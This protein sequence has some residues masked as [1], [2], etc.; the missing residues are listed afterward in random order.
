MVGRWCG[1]VARAGGS[2]SVLGSAV[3]SRQ[4]DRAVAQIRSGAKKCVER[5][6][7]PSCRRWIATRELPVARVDEPGVMRAVGEQSA[8]EG[9]VIADVLSHER[10]FFA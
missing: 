3:D 4:E 10:A 6:N 5:T 8:L 1:D 7:K 2:A 9:S